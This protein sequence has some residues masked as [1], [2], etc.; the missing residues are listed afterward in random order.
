ML[1]AAFWSHWPLAGD[2]KVQR[3][4][5][6]MGWKIFEMRHVKKLGPTWLV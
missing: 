5:I 2:D 1:I 6:N 4:M 3:R